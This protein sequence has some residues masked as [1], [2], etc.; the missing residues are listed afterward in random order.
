MKD[1]VLKTHKPRNADTIRHIAWLFI[2]G[3]GMPEWGFLREHS[4][5]LDLC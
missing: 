1:N 5:L 3:Q 4:Y 2:G